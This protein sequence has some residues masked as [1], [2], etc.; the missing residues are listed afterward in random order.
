MGLNWN[1]STGGKVSVRS[2]AWNNTYP[3]PVRM[4]FL[5]GGVDKDDG[6]YP[7]RARIH[8][9]V[10]VPLLIIGN[11]RLVW[12]VP[13]YNVLT[14]DGWD[15]PTWLDVEVE[16]WPWTIDLQVNNNYVPNAYASWIVHIQEARAAN[17]PLLTF[18]AF[19]FDYEGN[20]AAPTP[21]ENAEAW[22]HLLTEDGKRVRKPRKPRPRQPGI[23]DRGKAPRQLSG[24]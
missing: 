14:P 4:E 11:S 23:A 13:T 8:N 16:G 15:G 1:T 22:E 3:C 12:G 18:E 7:R 20:D 21:D 19:E 10:D 2:G 9:V 17:T 24:E 5:D 6:A